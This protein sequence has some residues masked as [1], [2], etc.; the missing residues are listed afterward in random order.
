MIA[1]IGSRQ[2]ESNTE[3]YQKRRNKQHR[4]IRFGSKIRC[5][6]KTAAAT[7]TA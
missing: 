3:Q 1:H 4:K 5:A 7:S 2:K 6:N